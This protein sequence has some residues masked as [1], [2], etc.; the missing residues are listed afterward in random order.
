MGI[1]QS[2]LTSIRPGSSGT[3]TTAP[4]NQAV[5]NYTSVWPNVS[6]SSTSQESWLEIYQCI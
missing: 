1:G 2:L 6:T 4:V 5:G 3:T